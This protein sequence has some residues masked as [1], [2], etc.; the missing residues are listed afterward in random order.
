MDYL[1]PQYGEG[2]VDLS[3]GSGLFT[4]RFAKSGKFSKVV[5]V[6]FSENMLIQT[7]DFIKEDKQIDASKIKLIRADVCRLPFKTGSVSAIHAGTQL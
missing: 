4:R 7:G 2:I 1:Q 5:A 6:D 3:C